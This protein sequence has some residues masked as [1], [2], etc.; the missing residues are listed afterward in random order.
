MT[1]RLYSNTSCV[2]TMSTL[3]TRFHIRGRCTFHQKRLSAQRALVWWASPRFYDW[4]YDYTIKDEMYSSVPNV[5]SQFLLFH[6]FVLDLVEEFPVYILFCMVKASHF[7]VQS[8]WSCIFIYISIHVLYIF[9]AHLLNT[10]CYNSSETP[11]HRASFL[12]VHD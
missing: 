10:D 12:N 8:I 1:D 3:M 5:I 11:I 9:A 2:H 7:I 6:I 4:D